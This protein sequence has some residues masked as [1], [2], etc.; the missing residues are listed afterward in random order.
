MNGI[1][2]NRL[3]DKLGTRMVPT[4]ELTLDGTLAVPVMGLKRRHQE[5]HADADHHAD[6]ERHRRR[7]AACV[8]ASRW[9]K[10]Y[11]KRRVAFGA[12]LAR[13]AAAHRHARVARGRVRGRV[14]AHV[15]RRR[16]ARQGRG[17][18]A[19]RAR[20]CA[21]PSAHPDRE[22]HHGEAGGRRSRARCS[23]RSAARAT[24]RTRG[25]RG[26][27][28]DAQVLPI[29]EG[30]TNVLS[31]DLLRAL[32][33][34]GS[35]EPIAREVHAAVEGADRVARRRRPRRRCAPSSTRRRG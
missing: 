14:P 34:L 6:V 19:R 30:T 1:Q 32:A 20:G 28:R 35:L 29:W 7:S 10:D 18:R 25:C 3:K 12:P 21:A 17:G 15:P 5:H 33:K 4:A 8:T 27:S 24:S 11:A 13:E 23:S 31:L 9:R 2:V 16:A 22:A 26:C